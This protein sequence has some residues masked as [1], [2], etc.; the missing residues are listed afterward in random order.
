MKLNVAVCLIG[1]D[2]KDVI[3]EDQKPVHFRTVCINALMAQLEEDKNLSGEDKVNAYTLAQRIFNDDECDLT[4]EDLT[5]LKA[6]VGKCYGPQIV[7]PAFQ[8]LN[9]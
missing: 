6:R 2:G 8:L 5:L 7:G 4:P 1:F 9:G 3:G